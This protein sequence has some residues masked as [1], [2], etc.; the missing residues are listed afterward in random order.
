MAKKKTLAQRIA[1]DPRLK[2]KYLANPG[3]RSKLPSSM[4]T[5]EQRK[6]REAQ[7]LART[8][9][10]PGSSLT[11][12]DLARE[13][14]NAATVRYG[15]AEQELAKQAQQGIAL[16]RDTAGWYDAYRR[17]L[18]QHAQNT[19]AIQAATQ[20][21]ML[22]QGQ[23]MR[24]LD[25]SNLQQSQTAADQS[26]AMRGATAAN[27]AP[28]AND[29]SLV[30]QQMFA[31]FG[32][33]QAAIGGA[34]GQYADTMANV[35]APTQKLRAMGQAAQ[36]VRDV[37][38]KALQ[39]QKEKG[40][41]ADTYKQ[42]RVADEFKNVLSQQALGLDVT[43]AK[44]DASEGAARI[45]IARGVDP[46]TG[47]RIVKPKSA[48]E[49]KTEADLA[50]FRKH[51]YYPTHGPGTAGKKVDAATQRKIQANTKTR[52]SIRTASA[53]AK[54]LRT[55]KILVPGPDGKPETKEKDGK[56]VPTGRKRALTEPEIRAAIRK[57]YKDADIA[58]AAMDLAILGHVSTENRRR[59]KARGIGV[60]KAWLPKK[61]KPALPHPNP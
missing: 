31:G 47:K 52:S 35:V 30:R 55:Q 45:D 49:K 15:S 38:E 10:T 42:G 21:Q 27:L 11:N 58:N 44:A 5:P 37:G 29:A 50:Y 53:D 17:E 56:Q 14:A 22:A 46:V 25:Q 18:A 32:A 33:Q 8:P 59:L 2:A 36:G 41:Y 20:Q 34:H 23:G 39:L 19:Q 24:A 28:T 7:T 54:Y 51:G 16:G 60:P 1:S 6:R 4:L 26:A 12:A 43:K 40:A 48:T 3:L 57:K 9:V 61:A 13:T